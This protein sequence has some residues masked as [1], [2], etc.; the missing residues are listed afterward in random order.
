MTRIIRVGVT[1]PPNLLKDFDDVIEPPVE[2]EYV[3]ED[4]YEEEEE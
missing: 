4:F 1:F 3:D 2:P